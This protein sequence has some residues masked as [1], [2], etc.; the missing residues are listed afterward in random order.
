MGLN[1]ITLHTPTPDE[2]PLRV[3]MNEA[4]VRELL[5]RTKS[6]AVA[7][8]ATVALLWMI[9][10]SSTGPLVSALFVTLVSFAMIRLFG[11][12]WLERRPR[13]QFHSMR[14]FYWFTAMSALIGANLGAIVMAS[15]PHISPLGV[16]MCSVAVIGINSGALVSLASSPL[17][18]LLYVGFNMAAGIFVAFAHPLPGQEHVFQ[19]TQLIYSMAL[20]MLLRTVHRSF[21]GNIIVRLRLATSLEQLRYTQVK[22]VDAS[23]QAGRADVAIEV[24]H[25]LGNVLNSVNVSATRVA[26]IAATSKTHNLSKVVSMIMEHR[27]GFGRFFRDDPR[28]QKLPD[29]FM[30]LV[31][32]VER[33]NL[34]LKTEVEALTRNVDHMKV[35]VAAQEAQANRNNVAETVDVHGLLDDALA[36]GAASYDEHAVVV[37]RRFDELPPV[38]V[39]RHKALQILIILLANARD[40]VMTKAP[41]ERRVIVHARRAATGD[42]EIAIEDNGCGIAPENLDRIFGLGFTT[43]SGG[44]GLGLHYSACAARQLNGNLTAR[45]PGVGS[46]ASFMLALPFANGP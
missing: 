1:L 41:G 31:A 39:D 21:R 34:V 15:Y 5:I 35:I 38:S 25:G 29:Y 14:A 11:T 26:D 19:V 23:R 37:L 30:Q 10:G 7:L 13:E 40:A 4:L 6:A 20:V 12:L 18:Y 16:A 24:L 27:D 2:A 22:L 33:D 3:P 36:A 44:D 9:V 42:L 45:S 32:V 17:V 46:G 28:G 8:L 43:K